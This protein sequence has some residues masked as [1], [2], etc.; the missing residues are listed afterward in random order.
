ML[1]FAR[2]FSDFTYML[3]APVQVDFTDDHNGSASCDEGVGPGVLQEALGN[4]PPKTA[5]WLHGHNE[6]RSLL[7]PVAEGITRTHGG[8]NAFPIS[9]S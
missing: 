9:R 7:D 6:V 4:P 1:L 3:S 8:K 5:E 2:R